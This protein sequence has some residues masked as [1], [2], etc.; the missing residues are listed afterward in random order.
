MF[1]QLMQEKEIELMNAPGMGEP[2][3]ELIPLD[4]LPLPAAPEG[5]ADA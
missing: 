3:P 5:D 1:E 4:Q 2:V